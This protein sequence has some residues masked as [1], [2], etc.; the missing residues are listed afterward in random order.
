MSGN[1]DFVKRA[2]DKCLPADDTGLG[3]DG[4]PKG[5]TFAFFWNGR[6]AP[7]G[8]RPW[9]EGI[10]GP[11]DFLLTKPLVHAHAC[12]RPKEWQRWKADSER[13]IALEADIDG[14]KVVDYAWC[15]KDPKDRT[16][17]CYPGTKESK[18][19]CK[20]AVLGTVQSSNGCDRQE[21]STKVLLDAPQVFAKAGDCLCTCDFPRCIG[22][23]YHSLIQPNVIQSDGRREGT[24]K[25]NLNS[26]AK[27]ER[28]CAFKVEQLK[29]HASAHCSVTNTEDWCTGVPQGME[30]QV[31]GRTK[32]EYVH[33]STNA[34]LMEAWKEIDVPKLIRADS[35]RCVDD[36]DGVRAASNGKA[37][38]CDA[39]ARH[40]T[41]PGIGSLVRQNCPRTCGVCTAG[42][43]DELEF[44][45]VAGMDVNLEDAMAGENSA[46]QGW[47]TSDTP[48]PSHSPVSNGA[49]DGNTCLF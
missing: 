7:A 17:C 45:S 47:A 11:G 9:P 33:Q 28:C 42:L 14:D 25:R 41:E 48:T 27:L 22:G 30:V 24:C 40:C 35:E 15:S 26:Y 23:K 21:N 8:V 38:S 32:Q 3:Y 12:K 34:C 18:E 2:D 1:L 13:Y 39:V 31:G 43:A 36:D 49:A 46:R 5:G 29:R 10:Y 19:R 6:A 4:F 37:T 44:E 16:R 20:D